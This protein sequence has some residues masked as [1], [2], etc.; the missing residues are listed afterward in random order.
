[1]DYFRLFFEWLFERF[2]V[3]H[4]RLSFLGV[5]VFAGLVGCFVW[6]MVGYKYRRDH[7]Q[8]V[9]TS[10][11]TSSSPGTSPA[12]QASDQGT[13]KTEKRSRASEHES[14]EGQGDKLRENSG[15]KQPAAPL[16][17]RKPMAMQVAV[18]RGLMRQL[19]SQ[20]HEEFWLSQLF[21]AMI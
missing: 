1:M 21:L 19:S 18:V 7:P 9:E 13:I 10:Q 3:Q 6:W 20:G 5:F 8:H 12:E 4:P 15:Q 14:V 2:G 16:P 17:L 11:A